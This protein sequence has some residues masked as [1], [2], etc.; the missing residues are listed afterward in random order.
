MPS[1]PRLYLACL[2]VWCVT[3][4]LT[5]PAGAAQDLITADSDATLHRQPGAWEQYQSLII[6]GSLITILQSAFIVALLVQRT[7]RKRAE[8]AL[9]ES[10]ER[11]RLMADT[12]PVL[13]W[14]S[15]PDKRCDFVN[16]PWLEFTGRTVAQELG[17]GWSEGIC[18]DDLDRFLRTYVSAFDARQPFHMEYRLRRA[19]GVYRW[20][21]N[22]GVARHGPDGSFAGYIGSCLDITDRKDSEDALR[23]SQ[24]RY[25]MATA[26][27]ALGV[28]DWNFE[29]DKLYVDPTLK[30]LLGF[31]DAEITNRPEDWGSRV[32]PEDLPAAAAR[33]K[34]CIDGEADVYEI[35]H[36]MLHKDGSA[37]WFLSRGS[38]MRGVDGTLQRLVGT[39]VDITKRKLAEEAILENE[40]AL[41]ASNREIRHLAGSLISAQ[42]AERARIARDLHDDVSQQ[43]AALSMAL[44]GLKRRVATMRSE[45]D[46]QDDFSSLE[47][48]TDTLAESLR[49]LSH[50][51][52]PDV[53]LHGGLA[54]ALTA[55][56]KGPSSSPTLAVTCRT[57]GNFESLEPKVALC[58]YR[59]AQEALHNVVKHAG[60]GQAEV[61]LL[62]TGDSAEL[63]I[64]D[65]G[66]GFDIRTRKSGAGLGLVSITERARLAGGTVSIVTALNKGTQIR[67]Q[68]PINE[69]TM[70]DAGDVSGRFAASA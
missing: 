6:G 12:A 62:R 50:D 43:L 36:R 38:A 67:V 23:E 2:V 59:I 47:Q 40:A 51:L 13:V 25:A 30:S 10:E 33:V 44:S 37:K 46:L 55:Y 17:N 31:E 4:V 11:F 41:Q 9:R 64:A 61:R 48:R 5:V 14:R 24:Q 52:H 35:E 53:L 65:D 58:L 39:K 32:H 3:G 16:R 27:G 60:A 54:A 57:E 69:R 8:Q 7:R 28:W 70:T 42:D 68:I 18:P 49:D 20:I 1:A 45:T 26:A 21:L 34:A 19:D 66:K 56:C 29:T 15:G 22:T 63:T